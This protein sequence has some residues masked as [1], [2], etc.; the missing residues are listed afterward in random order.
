MKRLLILGVSLAL[1][2]SASRADLAVTATR[3]YTDDKLGLT[4][5]SG[6]VDLPGGGAW[7]L[8][9]TDAAAPLRQVQLSRSTQ[10]QTAMR[11]NRMRKADRARQIEAEIY[12][13]WEIF[14][15]CSDYARTNKGIGPNTWA[16]IPT[17]KMRGASARFAALSTNF[18]LIPA[19]AIQHGG[20]EPVE[21][22][23]LAMQLHPLVA[24]GK[25]WVVYNNGQNQRVPIDQALCATLGVVIQPQQAPETEPPPPAPSVSHYVVS[26][27]VKPGAAA[28]ETRLALTNLA[29]GAQQTCVW[30]LG[31]AAAGERDVLTTWAGARAMQ[32]MEL[33]AGG[34]APVLWQWLSR[35]ETLY[36]ARMPD[37]AGNRGRAPVERTDAFGVLGGRAAVRETLQL[38]P[39]RPGGAAAATQTIALATIPGVTVKA[40]PFDAML[41]GVTPGT[42]ALAES[43]PADRAFV[44]FPKPGALLPL[45]DGGADFAFQGGALAAANPAAYDLKRRYV[46][47]LGLSEQWMR[48]LLINS[49]A[50]KEL[51]VFFPDLFFIDG[52]DVTILARIPAARLL[53]PALGALGIG[54]LTG[55]VQERSGKAGNSYWVMD[56][57]MLIIGTAR[58]EV[59]RVL[60][61]RQAGGAGSLGQ[62]AEFHYMLAQMP[63]KAE[64]R[65]YCYL[66]D[67]FIRRLVGPEV[68]I[69]QLRRLAARG[70]MESVTAAALLY[71][72]DAQAGQPS[73]ATL[74]EKGYLAA[75]P[76]VARDCAMDAT[77]A[78]S[79]PAY[80]PA[81]R[82]KTLL[83][84]PVAAATRAEADAYRAYV[85]SYARFWRQYFD[86]MAFRLDDGPAGELQLSTF[87]LPLVDNTIYNGL[88]EVLCHKEDGTPL[89]LPSLNPK[90]LLLLSA[91]LSE[92]SWTKVTQDMFVDLLQRFTTLDPT[93]FDKI[94]PGIHLAIHDADPIL[95]FGAG[96]ALG[97]LGSPAEMGR[98]GEMLL[99]PAVA[100]I[101][102]RPC[103]LIV[104]L[105]DPDGMRR[106]LLASA[107]APLDRPP[108]WE[109]VASFYKVEGREAWVCTISIENMV[110]IRFG[111]EIQDKYLILSNLPWS[112]KPAFGLS[113][114]AELNAMA[115]DLHPAAG[116]LQRPGL[117]TAACEQERAAAVQ[118]ERYL[119]PLL[120]CGAGSVPAALNQCRD[121][122]GFAP[123][124]PGSGQ[125]VWE[126]D[127][128]CSTAY[129]DPARPL[130]PEY[131][132]GD[133]AF[134]LLGGLETL[135]LNLQFEDA[136]LRVVTRWKMAVARPAAR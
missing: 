111:V 112:Q 33:A 19:V 118:G 13:A 43:V 99:I 82:L 101:L 57:D 21:R 96:D 34:D 61:L 53:K 122:F 129:G 42:L 98:G 71:R 131:K 130:Q 35:C 62:S 89:N 5:V 63:V 116:V 124:H 11:G 85:E 2:V 6:T 17:N 133:Q 81:A 126:H 132:P 59:E 115:L 121:L 39:L 9:D 119:Y 120:A 29:T 95:T 52:T 114:P 88:K 49:G 14:Q 55:T 48:D 10:D 58:G 90:P 110:R 47:R 40:H 8:A 134:G 76:T 65:A 105:Q 107:H 77:L 30:N 109:P 20:A 78:A 51:A 75:E 32:W 50:V 93:A 66:S 104:E 41:K 92:E 106:M 72:L 125:W 28:H 69:G 23:P 22:R 128:V 102:T 15:A 113:R 97:I 16:D 70:E 54:T 135:N 60:G 84:S 79:C 123:E 91:N 64:S 45:L 1:G 3:T 74:L 94:G 12:P 56:G 67:P 108:R 25:H 117:F 31:Q 46:E 18:F 86:P 38:E 36:G 44:Y 68:K 103:Q 4:V 24:D 127:R 136:G 37:F 27:L 73:V 100:S 87:I 26:A 80:G 7:T 83:D